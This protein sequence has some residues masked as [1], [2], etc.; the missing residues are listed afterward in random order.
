[1]IPNIFLINHFT[2]DNRKAFFLT[3]LSYYYNN[4]DNHYNGKWYRP[5]F[6]NLIQHRFFRFILIFFNLQ[7]LLMILQSI[8]FIRAICNI[9]YL[10]RIFSIIQILIKDQLITVDRF[11]THDNLIQRNHFVI[12]FEN[13]VA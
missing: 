2:I 10:N 5:P 13:I 3:I 8:L 9:I 1:M 4:K 12:F 7:R 11:I 6:Q